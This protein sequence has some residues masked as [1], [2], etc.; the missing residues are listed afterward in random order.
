MT[1]LVDVRRPVGT[2]TA[3]RPDLDRLFIGLR[4]AVLIPC[5][6]EEAA[7][8][9]VIAGFRASLPT[10]TIYVYDNNSVDRTVPR[11]TRCWCGGAQ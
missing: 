3:T 2:S 4:V 9:R 6:N 5:F 10:T 7:V 1:A 8:A 11:C